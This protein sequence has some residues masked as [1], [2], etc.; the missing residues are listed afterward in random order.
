MTTQPNEPITPPVTPPPADPPAAPPATPPAS[1]PAADPA[2]AGVTP[3]PA[4][5]PAND[6]DNPPGSEALGDPGKRA[7][8]AMK[9]QRDL[10]KDKRRELERKLAEATA[11][12]PGDE[13][14]PE[15]LREQIR[16]E[17]R[18]ALREPL[19]KSEIKSVAATMDAHDPADLYL[20]LNLKDF[21]PDADGLFDADEIKEK[22][23][24]LRASKPHLFK[25][26]AGQSG[27]GQP[28]MVPAP[29]AHGNP[30]KAPTLDEQIAAATAAKNFSLVIR[31]QNQKL[32]DGK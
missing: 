5:P 24:E 32:A 8:D 18:A 27:T 3:P 11:P 26:P 9:K 16:A 14:T 13:Q 1:T 25:T 15:Q 21:D 12:K 28:P 19:L 22:L 4:D 17:E 7:L 10:E 31:L 6:A 2:S 23:T 20:F 30:P 29:P